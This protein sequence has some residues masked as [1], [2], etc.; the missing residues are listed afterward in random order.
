MIAGDAPQAVTPTPPDLQ[1]PLPFVQV[2]FAGHN[3]PE[4]LGDAA[5]VAK[6][7][8]DAFTTLAAAG[9]R[10]GR[11]IT[12]LA[13]GADRLAVEAWR[14][15]DLGPIHAVHPFLDD[16]ASPAAAADSETWLDGVATEAHGRSP[17]LAQTRWLIGAAD[18]LVVAWNGRPARGAGGTADAVRLALERGVPVLWV[19]PAAPEPP[20]LIRSDYLDDDF[21][22]LEVLDQLAL[23]RAPLVQPATADNLR[24][25]LSGL[26]REA[27]AQAQ[28]AA[29]AQDD[30][31]LS[32]P[33]AWPWRTYAV[34]RKLLGGKAAPFTARPTPPDL[35]AQ[36]G[37]ASLA[38]ARAAADARANRLGAVHRSHQV[39]LLAVAIL[40]ACAGSSSVLWPGLK[41]AM[42]TVELALALGALVVWL[43]SER[44][45]RHQRWGEARKLA[46]DLRL[47]QAAWTI[48][49]TAAAQG[50][51]QLDN[52]G[53]AA[54]RLR[55]LAG[56]PHGAFG[57]ERVASWGGWAVDELITGQVAYHR[58]QATIS[59][60]VSHRVHQLEN[61][62]FG[63]LLSMLVGYVA[64]A[65]TLTA[66]GRETP[67]WLGGLVVMAGVVVPA[68]GAAS[69]ALE[70]TLALGEQARRS[71]TLAAQLQTLAPPPGAPTGLDRI[72]AIARIAIRLQR[73]Q[74]DH[75][76]EDAQ[77][78]RLFRG[79]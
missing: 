2:A 4:D 78:R 24:D 18:L 77:R 73:L 47:E 42:V 22:F 76:T 11:L 1:A 79:G 39:I 29:L 63:V 8:G 26:A 66:L 67:H 69:L 61:I 21:G 43:D 31:A 10:Q 48:G 7:L 45:E 16:A 28:A 74:E 32:R 65:L 17:Y 71:R 25:A 59:G 60:R 44:G 3:R 6:A 46:E 35:L 34:F 20:R 55:R 38:R 37:F 70:A 53:G 15:A 56:L 64:V 72:Q 27:A 9:L 51:S 58:A 49:V 13:D 19:D 52:G 62:S 57:P 41:L 14:R 12:G 33:L 23:S 75:W 50:P 30:D 54:Q 68:I 5:A 40:A 36:D